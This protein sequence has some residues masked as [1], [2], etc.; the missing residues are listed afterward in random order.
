MKGRATLSETNG[1][2][3]KIAGTIMKS[4]ATLSETN[5]CREKQL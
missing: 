5:R 4:R 3:E 1:C 2:R